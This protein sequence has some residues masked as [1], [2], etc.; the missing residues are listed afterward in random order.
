MR[1]KLAD[2]VLIRRFLRGT[3]VR[4][5]RYA[6]SSGMAGRMFAR[7]DDG[8]A[9]WAQIWSAI[10][11]PALGLESSYC[12]GSIIGVPDKGVLYFGKGSHGREDYLLHSSTDGLVWK[13]VAEVFKAGAAYSDLTI[14]GQGDVGVVFERGTSDR[15]P[16]VWL[17]FGKVKVG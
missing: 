11:D 5:F 7:S 2:V 4:L 9:N 16:Y 3:I 17:T 14:T 1:L 13:E 8:G 6:L 15:N 12:E 10:N